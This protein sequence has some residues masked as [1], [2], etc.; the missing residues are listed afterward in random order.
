MGSWKYSKQHLQ[1][2]PFVAKVITLTNH[3]A[4]GPGCKRNEQKSILCFFNPTTT[5]KK[6]DDDVNSDDDWNDWESEVEDAIDDDDIITVDENEDGINEKE[7]ANIEIINPATNQTGRKR[8]PC[9]GLCSDLIAKYKKLKPF[10][11]CALNQK[12]YAESQWHVDKDCI[13][14]CAKECTGYF[15]SGKTICNEYYLLKYNPILSYRLTIPKLAP[16]N[17]KFIPKFYFENNSL[18]KHLQNQDLREIWSVIKDNY[19]TSIWITL[20]NKATNGAFKEKPVFTGLCKVMIQAA[21]RKDNNKGKHNIQYNEDF[22]NFLIILESFSTRALDLFCQNL[23]GRPIVAMSNNTKLKPALRYNPV[24]GC[25]V[26]STLST[27][28]TKINKYKDIQPII[29]NI[30]T[31]K[32]IAKDDTYYLNY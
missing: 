22:T 14:V 20:D 28:Q 7:N 31:K 17:L 16:E 11:K 32:A 8:K 30:K 18:K 29:N 13:T 19:D 4:N 24:L 23:E 15:D 5:D 27:E 21:I 1:R 26:G 6:D 10:Q 25:I 9:L 3:H 2:H 12:I